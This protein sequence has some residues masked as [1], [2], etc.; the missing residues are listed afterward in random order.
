MRCEYGHVSGI[1]VWSYPAVASYTWCY[2]VAIFQWCATV[3]KESIMLRCD[4][5]IFNHIST[6]CATAWHIKLIKNYHV[7]L[8]Y[9]IFLIMI[10]LCKI[11]FSLIL[12]CKVWYYFVISKKAL[13]SLR[14]MTLL[15]HATQWHRVCDTIVWQYFI[16]MCYCNSKI[17]C[18]FVAWYFY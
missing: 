5:I 1:T 4:I 2:C 6:Q 10:L 17:S 3:I 12:L 13:L 15:N 14:G 11:K 16:V 18:H 9:D 7:I 8:W